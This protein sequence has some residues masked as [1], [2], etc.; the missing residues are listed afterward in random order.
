LQEQKLHELQ[1]F[2]NGRA[3]TH[4][5]NVVGK[6]YPCGERCTKQNST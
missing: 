1:I 3:S 2:F 4:K 5:K 6:I